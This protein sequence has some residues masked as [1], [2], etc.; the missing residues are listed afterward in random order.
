MRHCTVSTTSQDGQVHS[1]ETD[2]AS[3]FEAAHDAVHQWA[4]LWWFSGDCVIEVRAGD[5]RWRV[6][7]RR[8]S[9]WYAA[10]FRHGSRL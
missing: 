8:V 3:L 7:A 4:P 6:R 1:I 2:A 10:R 5:Q 9:E